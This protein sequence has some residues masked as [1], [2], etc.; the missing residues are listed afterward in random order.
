MNTWQGA[1]K[2]YLVLLVCVLSAVKAVRNPAQLRAHPL[3]T[4]PGKNTSFSKVGLSVGRHSSV[5]V[6]VM[7][8]LAFLRSNDGLAL[9]IPLG[10]FLPK[11]LAHLRSLVDALDWSYTDQQVKSVLRQECTRLG[12]LPP[13][14]NEFGTEEF[15]RKFADDLV[16]V[17]GEELLSGSKDG[18]AALC[19]AYYDEHVPPASTSKPTTATTTTSPKTTRPSSSSKPPLTT[20]KPP[21]SPKSTSSS[22]PPS[23]S[24]MP[25]PPSTTTPA[26]PDPAV[27]WDIGSSA[28]KCVGFNGVEGELHAKLQNEA[29]TLSPDLGAHCEAWDKTLHPACLDNTGGKWCSQK[30]CFVDPCTCELDVPPKT[31][32]YVTGGLFHGRTLYFSYATCGGKDLYTAKHLPD[33]C[34]NQDSKEKCKALNKCAWDGQAKACFGKELVGTCGT[35]LDPFVAGFSQCRCIGIV[36]VKGELTAKHGPAKA[37]PADIGS[38]CKAWDENL[39]SDCLV[40]GEAPKWCHQK[41]CYVDPCTCVLPDAT[42]PKLSSYLPSAT[43]RNKHLYYSYA[44][45]KAGA[46]DSYTAEKNP[47]ACVNQDAKDACEALP[48]CS[49]TG[50]RCLGK[51]LVSVC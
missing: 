18:Y 51:E 14:E 3:P 39:H 15:C 17:R 48:K 49:W 44:T 20:S 29:V 26:L 37:V 47:H 30:W 19:K 6:A 38:E 32:S 41:W 5:D 22:K 4:D 23:S 12:R 16:A 8:F 2:A 42:P 46:K 33:A 11:C 35:A 9:D 34:V 27:M 24:S 10:T 1:F 31:S 36:G 45:C 40:E 21:S 13:K 28:C 43:F 50:K 25:P 7:N